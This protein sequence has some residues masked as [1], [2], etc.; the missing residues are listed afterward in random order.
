MSDIRCDDWRHA[1]GEVVAQLLESERRRWIDSLHWDMGPSFHSL[2]QA[3]ASGEAAGLIAHDGGG[4]AAGWTYYLLQN[5]RLQIGGLV[6]ESGEV[7]RQLLDGVLK[8]PEADMASEVLCFAFPASPSLEGALARR[9]F[10]VRKYFYLRRTLSPSRPV[11]VERTALADQLRPWTEQD[12][13]DTVRLMARA[14]A[15]VPSARS[16][17]PK[18]TL[19]EWATYLAQLIKTPACGRFLPEASLSAQHP[20]DDRL[21][22]VVLTTAL[23]RDTAHVAQLAIDPAWRRRGLARALMQAALE[24]AAAAGYWRLTL[25]VAEENVAARELYAS[26]G[27]EEHGHFLYAT[28]SAPNRLRGQRPTSARVAVAA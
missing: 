25:L 15:G 13:V 9:R 26:L 1:P 11:A 16:F 27:F 4:R 19:E 12:G 23:Q 28:R 8:A 2:E 10:D 18:G 5:R 17:A 21:R 7:T 14:Y 6:A 24:R 22:G 20:A 3:R